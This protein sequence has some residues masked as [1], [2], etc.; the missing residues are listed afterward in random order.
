MEV[1]HVEPQQCL[2]RIQSFYPEFND[3]E[4]KI[5]DYILTAPEKI[6]NQTITQVAEDV[7]VASSTIFRFC[8]RMGFTGYQKLKIA[9]AS[10]IASPLRDMV[11][12]KIQEQDNERA[13]TEKIFNTSIRTFQDTIQTMD[14]SLIKKAVNAMMAAEK[15]EFYG[16]GNSGIV[17]LDAHH[18]FIGSGLSTNAYTDPYLQRRAASQLSEDDIAFIIIGSDA[19]DEALAVFEAAKAAGAK[20]I[21][22]TNMMRS[23]M[24]KKADIMLRTISSGI[25]SRTDDMYSRIVQMSLIDALYTNVMKARKPAGTLGKLKRLFD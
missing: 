11:Q 21:V 9:L 3:T 20:T 12:E 23:P 1:N 13:V 14:F 22:M 5:A 2:T 24:N 6:M 4:K 10:E 25:E 16:T 8:Q 19:P 7:G 17:A 18:K 15:V